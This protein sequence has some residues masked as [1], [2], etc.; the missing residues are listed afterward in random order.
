MGCT[1]NDIDGVRA[2][3]DD[4]RHGIDHVLDAFTWREEAER[5]N[6]RLCAEAEFRLGVMR[7]EEREI[8]YSVRY[9]LNLRLWRT[10]D[11]TKEFAAFFC[12]D[13]DLGRNIDDPTHHVA[14]GGRRVGKYR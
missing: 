9:D 1:E 2:G 4:S 11:E 5:K 12:H 6:D 8:R 13:N 7:F 3:F 10:I 14:L